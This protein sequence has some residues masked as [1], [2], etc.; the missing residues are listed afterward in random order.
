LTAEPET[1]VNVQL[2]VCRAEF[3]Q[4]LAELGTAPYP[5]PTPVSAGGDRPQTQVLAEL[6]DYYRAAWPVASLAR[7]WTADI[8]GRYAGAA[9][10]QEM[11]IE[12]DA[13][14]VRLAQVCAAAAL[15]PDVP[16]AFAATRAFRE[17]LLSSHAWAVRVSDA[18]RCCGASEARKLEGGRL[19][20]AEAIA[21]AS[22]SIN[23]VAAEYGVSAGPPGFSRV[24]SSEVLG[25]SVRLPYDWPVLDDSA[26]VVALAPGQW[27]VTTAGGSGPKYWALGT[28]LRIRRLRNPPGWDLNSALPR[29]DTVLSPFGAAKETRPAR[30]AGLQA[31]EQT[32]VDETANWRTKVVIT[33]SGEFTFLIESGCP[34]HMAQECDRLFA[35]LLATVTLPR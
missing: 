32:R 2:P 19:M 1:P 4:P 30:I 28:A 24:V 21:A 7:S 23:A 20:A 14:G 3:N 34:T 5:T 9:S 10:S 22:N 27:Q 25:V 16:E 18:L 8:G 35:E 31:I 29:A 33:V 15:L 12:L 11:G 17:A 6:T 26:Q 13:F